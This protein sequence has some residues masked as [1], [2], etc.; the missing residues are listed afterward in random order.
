MDVGGQ[1]SSFTKIG[2]LVI[3]FLYDVG[4]MGTL[5]LFSKANW[6]TGNFD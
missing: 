4:Y 6:K 3:L 1:A 2:G 5:E